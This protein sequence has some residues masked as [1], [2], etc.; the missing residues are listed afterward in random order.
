MNGHSSCVLVTG[1]FDPIHGGHI[2]YFEDAKSLSTYLIVGVNSDEWLR[3]KKGR[4]FMSWESRKRI[5][6]QMNIVDYVIDFDDSDGSANDAIE[7]CLKDFD[8][9]IFCNGGDRGEDNI[10]EYEK[11]KNNKRVE[12]KYSVGGGKTESSSEL[13]NAYSNPITYRAWGH[14]RVLYEGKD[15]KVKEIVIK[16]H[17]ELSMQRHEHRSETWNLVSG[18]AKLRLIQ[19]GEVVEHDL[20]STTVIPKGTWHQGYNDSNT[21]AHIVEIWRGDTE[22]LNEE[23][24]ERKN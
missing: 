9:V 15:Y 4:P 11:Y 1:G 16:P 10:P 22:H 18:N 13:L 24:I 12:F 5:I 2:D 20:L 7:Q 21:P 23:D 8:K 14:Y 3:R 17:S 19:H 6:D